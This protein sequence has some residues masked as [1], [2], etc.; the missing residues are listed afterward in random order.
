VAAELFHADGQTD[1]TK[2]I[3]AFR[4][5]AN[6]PGI[7]F[8]GVSWTNN[9]DPL[10]Q[11]L[12]LLPLLS[13]CHLSAFGQWRTW[14]SWRAFALSANPLWLS[15]HRRLASTATGMCQ[16]GD[17]EDTKA[18]WTCWRPNRKRASVLQSRGSGSVQVLYH[19]SQLLSNW[20]PVYWIA[21]CCRLLVKPCTLQQNVRRWPPLSVGHLSQSATFWRNQQIPVMLYRTVTP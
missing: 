2:L 1:T 12:L 9:A 17:A 4:N 11:L 14:L 15:L 6:A 3:V 18:L 21:P 5:F 16:A 7:R 20:T 13:V 19:C 10:V 8:I